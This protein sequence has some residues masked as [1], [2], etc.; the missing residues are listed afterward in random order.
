MGIITTKNTILKVGLFLCFVSIAI[1][2]VRVF[3]FEDIVV[4]LDESDINQFN[5]EL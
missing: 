3:F 1:L 4:F 2:A 5:I